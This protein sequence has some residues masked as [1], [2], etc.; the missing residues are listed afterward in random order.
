MSALFLKIRSLT[1][2]CYFFRDCYV[3][4]KQILYLPGLQSNSKMQNDNHQ[5]SSQHS[6]QKCTESTSC[7]LNKNIPL[8]FPQVSIDANQKM[9]PPPTTFTLDC[10]SKVID[11]I[12]KSF[13]KIDVK[14]IE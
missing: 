6:A 9:V 1:N 5:D 2:F 12:S 10:Q 14:Q 8:E 7:N 11:H 3:I 13:Y 4:P